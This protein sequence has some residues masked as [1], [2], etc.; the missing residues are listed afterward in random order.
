MAVTYRDYYEVLG[1]TRSASDEEIRR[2]YRQL[3][4]K[5]HPDTN[6][7]D[8]K[9]EDKFKEVNEAYEVLKDKEKRRRYDQLGPNW[10]QGQ[11]FR[12]PPGFG[13]GGG[14]FNF[15]GSG[16]FSDFFEAIFGGARTA[17]AG[18]RMHVNTNGGGRPGAQHFGGNPFFG[19]D[20][21]GGGCGT[22]GCGPSAPK[23]AEVEIQVPVDTV[24][25]GGTQHLTLNMS[26]Y[27][28]RSFDVQIPAGIEEGKKIRLS[29]EG[30]QGEDIHL[31]IKYA[32][33]TTYRFENGNLITEAK[34]SPARAALGGKAEV[35][36]PDGAINLTIP[37]GSSSGRRLRIRGKGMKNKAGRGDLLVQVMITIPTTLSKEEK[38]LYE[39]LLKKE[40]TD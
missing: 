4:R 17:N 11:E 12:P 1:V 8:P 28:Q 7:D 27:G 15:G 16:G 25:T 14:G 5:Y 32:P 24:V 6:K 35:E 9:S 31:K 38:A 30:P 40:S 18:P 2:A 23:A 20:M 21:G 36:T 26:G 3:A 29:G 13:G 34:I 22:G 39:Q 19:A 33:G 37:A 10:K